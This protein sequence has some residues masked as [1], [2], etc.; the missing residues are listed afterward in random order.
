MKR[1]LSIALAG[2]AL[3]G[4]VA[5]AP[6]ATGSGAKH[7]K[8]VCLNGGYPRHFPYQPVYKRKPRHC[9]LTRNNR[10][11]DYADSVDVKDLHWSSWGRFHAKGKGKTGLNMVGV[12]SIR[13]KLYRVKNI[14]GHRVFSRAKFRY[15]GQPSGRALHLETCA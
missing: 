9:V 11:P 3:V 12:V 10:P 13:V 1:A 7:R 8:V 5:L 14:C 6:A 15:K 4:V 2:A